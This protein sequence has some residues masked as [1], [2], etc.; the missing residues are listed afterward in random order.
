MLEKIFSAS[1]AD[2]GRY[3]PWGFALIALG[4]ILNITAGHTHRFEQHMIVLRLIALIL[5]AVGVLVTIKII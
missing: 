4:V 5:T 2:T 3:N 1:P